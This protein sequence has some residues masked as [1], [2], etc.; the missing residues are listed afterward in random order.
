MPT[1]HAPIMSTNPNF[2]NT[3]YDF[4]EKNEDDLTPNMLR[5]KD[6]SAPN[7]VFNTYWTSY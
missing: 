5:S 1:A 3:S 6:E 7:H 2:H 4:F